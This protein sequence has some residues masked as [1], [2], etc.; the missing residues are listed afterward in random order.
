[1]TPVDQCMDRYRQLRF[2]IELDS[3]L[4]A[5]LNEFMS[6]S[7]AKSLLREARARRIAIHRL[8]KEELGRR[9]M[10]SAFMPIPFMPTVFVKKGGAKMNSIAHE[11]GHAMDMK[12]WNGI[13]RMIQLYR[14]KYG[15]MERAANRQATG[16]L[17][18]IGTAADVKDFRAS[19]IPSQQDYRWAQNVF[20]KTGKDPVTFKPFGSSRP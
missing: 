14:R 11:I 2:L 3:R 15:P 18:R 7:T 6:L 4:G 1:M 17:S 10:N 12:G 5:A 20:R 19:R 8:P 13:K 9:N 16:L